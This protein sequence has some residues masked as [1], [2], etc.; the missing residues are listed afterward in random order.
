MPNRAQK[1]QHD[2]CYRFIAERDGEYCI[3]CFAEGAGRRGPKIAKLQIDHADNNPRNWIDVNLLH[4]VCQQHNIMFCPL[5]VREHISLMAG[6]S[7]KNESERVRQNLFQGEL[8]RTGLYA[9][10]SPEMQVNSI[11]RSKWLDF[12]HD[13]INSNGSI[14]KDI[15]IDAGAKIADDI[16]IQTAERYY[17]KEKSIAGAFEEIVRDGKKFLIYRKDNIELFKFKQ[18]GGK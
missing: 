7:A 15:A 3:A 18:S 6:Y 17:R 9:L 1:A 11:A 5:S 10:G 16:D 4:L 2:L 14:P 13:W 12:V 8:R